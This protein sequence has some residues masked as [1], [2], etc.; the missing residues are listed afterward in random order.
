MRFLPL[1]PGAVSLFFAF[2][3]LKFTLIPFMRATWASRACYITPYWVGPIG[4]L[5]SLPSF[6]VWS[7]WVTIPYLILSLFRLFKT[8][9][10]L[11]EGS[12]YYGYLIYIAPL[13]KRACGLN[14]GLIFYYSMDTLLLGP[15]LRPCL[16]ASLF[17]QGSWNM[18][19]LL[20]FAHFL[21]Y[22]LGQFG[23]FLFI[24][25]SGMN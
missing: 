14:L 2:S 18:A 19:Q 6:F 4:L 10:T 11:Q 15:L 12:F 24:G 21:T 16:F 1:L 17:F 13:L 5:I 25:P 7:C 9:F 8:H 23:V 22:S 3:K 20:S